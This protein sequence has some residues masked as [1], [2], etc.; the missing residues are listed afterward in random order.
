[1]P[2]WATYLG[3]SHRLHFASV[4]DMWTPAQ[5]NQAPTSATQHKTSAIFQIAFILNSKRFSQ[6]MYVQINKEFWRWSKET[7]TLN[8]GGKCYENV[9]I[10]AKYFKTHFL[11]NLDKWSLLMTSGLYFHMN[12]QISFASRFMQVLNIQIYIRVIYFQI[13]WNRIINW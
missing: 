9:C 4:S 3:D 13:S 10:C 7:N 11:N 12:L 8:K 6:N 2:R 1:M 5:I